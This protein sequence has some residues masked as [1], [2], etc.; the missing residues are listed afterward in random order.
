MSRFVGKV[1]LITGAGRGIGRAS[2]ERLGREGARVALIDRNAEQVEAAAASLRREGIDA[3]AWMCDVAVLEEVDRTVMEVYSALGGLD[4]VH[5][6]AGILSPASVM[7]ETLQ[8]WELTFSV[9]LT[10]VFLTLRAA[11]PHLLSGGGGAIV[12]TSSTAGLV[13]EPDF[14]AY[15]TSK[16]AVAHL[17][18]QVALDL[19]E[20][21]VRANAVCPGWVDTSFSDPILA[22]MSDE[23]IE[24][25]VRSAVPMGRMGKPEEVAAAVAFPRVRGC[26]IRDGALPRP[27]WRADDQ[28]SKS[29]RRTDDTGAPMPIANSRL[30]ATLTSPLLTQTTSTVA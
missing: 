27:R 26:V 20:S 25:E 18:R 10:G 21:G 7:Q 9:N 17:T 29:S 3:H 23:E 13:A 15:C 19:A 1:A 11:I 30:K 6:N 12:T 14:A 5:A 16:A 2:A 28:M 8:R 22:G 4:V 24:S